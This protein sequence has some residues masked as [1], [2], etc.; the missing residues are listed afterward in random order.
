MDRELRKLAADRV[1]TIINHL[2]GE[3]TVAGLIIVTPQGPAFIPIVPDVAAEC[4]DLIV[5]MAAK[6][7]KP[8]VIRVQVPPSN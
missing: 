5:R 4:A 7:D 8:E 3:M 1:A 2:P 6:I